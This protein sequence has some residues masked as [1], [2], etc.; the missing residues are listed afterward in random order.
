MTRPLQPYVPPDANKSPCP[1]KLFSDFDPDYL[2]K[3]FLDPYGHSNQTYDTMWMTS[4]SA[5]PAVLNG[6]GLM[7]YAASRMG[8][9][10]ALILIGSVAAN[11]LDVMIRLMQGVETSEG[12]KAY[13]SFEIMTVRTLWACRWWSS[14][15]LSMPGGRRRGGMGGAGALWL[16]VGD[17]FI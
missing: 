14:S 10:I 3:D 2:P 17:Y 11:L 5:M 1:D 15:P 7:A 13:T 9:G 8:L 4:E 12:L 16:R 6:D